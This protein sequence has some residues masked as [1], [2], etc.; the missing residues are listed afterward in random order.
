MQDCGDVLTAVDLTSDVQ[1]SIMAEGTI[2]SNGGKIP[3]DQALLTYRLGGGGASTPLGAAT[4][5]LSTPSPPSLGLPLMAHV[6]G[7]QI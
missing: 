7:I 5:G 1:I 3:P 6:R 2:H 4:S